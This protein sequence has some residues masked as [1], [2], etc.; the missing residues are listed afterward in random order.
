MSHH[1]PADTFDAM[2]SVAVFEHLLMPWKVAIEMNKVLRVGGV[3]RLTSHESFPLHEEPWDFFRFGTACWDTLFNQVTGFAVI[4]RSRVGEARVVPWARRSRVLRGFQHSVVMLR[5]TGNVAPG[6]RWDVRPESLLPE[7]HFYAANAASS[8][9][10][11]AARH[12]LQLWRSRIARF[13]PPDDPLRM[14]RRGPWWIIKSAIARA[15]EVQ[16]VE[17]KVVDGAGLDDRLSVALAGVGDG[18]ISRLALIDVLHRERQPWVVV[19]EINRVLEIG[20]LAYLEVPQVEDADFGG[21]RVSAEGLRGLFHVGSG[22]TMEASVM[23]DPCSVIPLG[24][25]RQ[26]VGLAAAFRRTVAMVRKIAPFDREAMHWASTPVQ[27]P[28][29]S[30]VDNHVADLRRRG[31]AGGEHDIGV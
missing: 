2:V 5:K 20:G 8:W 14:K 25:A 3:V 15:L 10:R 12:A 6:T 23:V 27:Q 28:A 26:D 19:E 22:F 13:D 29:E 1:F 30:F 4:G 7:G 11:R 21:W 16:T 24:G 17:C 9:P 31:G 18:A